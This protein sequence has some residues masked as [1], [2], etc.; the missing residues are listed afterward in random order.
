MGYRA[1]ATKT[2][3]HDRNNTEESQQ[4][5]EYLNYVKHVCNL[6]AIYQSH[7]Y[8]AVH[9]LLTIQLL[10]IKFRSVNRIPQFDKYISAKYYIY[11]YVRSLR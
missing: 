3:V 8:I 9:K 5:G 6:L 2:P 10:N 4:I 11:L 7:A 1:G